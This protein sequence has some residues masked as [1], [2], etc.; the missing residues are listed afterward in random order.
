VGREV[1]AADAAGSGG[2]RAAPRLADIRTVLAAASERLE[3]LTDA[4]L[5]APAAR[6]PPTP[7][8]T[9]RGDMAFLT[10]HVGQVGCVRKRLGYPGIVDGQ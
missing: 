6:R 4:D 9:V 7:D 5:S 3:N 10:Y 2:R 8:Q 1:R